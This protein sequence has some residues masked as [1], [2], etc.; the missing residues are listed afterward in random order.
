MADVLRSLDLNNE[1]S[2]CEDIY[3]N[4]PERQERQP[5]LRSSGSKHV[6]GNN[7]DGMFNKMWTF[8]DGG[9]IYE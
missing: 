2:S 4:L 5:S 9:E 7:V 3:Y 6:K 8:F 1:K